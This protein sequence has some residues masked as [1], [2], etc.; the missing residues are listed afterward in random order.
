MEWWYGTTFRE[1]N[2]TGS[3]QTALVQLVP[4]RCFSV[5]IVVNCRSFAGVPK[6]E[7]RVCG[8]PSKL[9]VGGS[10]PLARFLPEPAER[11]SV[12]AQRPSV[13]RSYWP[14]IFCLR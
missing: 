12:H 13:A 1:T 11:R 10:N 7:A 14:D 2:R 3:L 5:Q 6:T 9:Y 4:N 8:Q